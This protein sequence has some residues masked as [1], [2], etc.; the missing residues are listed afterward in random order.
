MLVVS[1]ALLAVLAAAVPASAHTVQNIVAPALPAPDLPPALPAVAVDPGSLA[2]PGDP[3]WPLAGALLL[4]LALGLA[5]ARRRPR[6]ALVLALVVLLTLFAFENAL[7]SVHHGFDAKQRN[8]CTIAAAAANLS[9]ISVDGV[10]ETSAILIPSERAAEPDLA[11][12]PTR[13]L[14]PDQGRAPPFP[15]A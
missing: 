5:G 7:H 13:L 3:S 11:P 4:S 9:A 8:E 15:T 2:S 10:P 14:E 12:P 1:L 6:R